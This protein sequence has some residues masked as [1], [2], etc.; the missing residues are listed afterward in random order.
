MTKRQ[1]R[2]R[3]DST[4]NLHR[5]VA[6][7]NVEIAPPAH[8]PLEEAD[9]PYWHSIIEEYAKADWTRH[10][11]DLAAFLARMMAN[12]EAQQRQLFAEGPVI[13]QSDGS[14][15]S[16][17]RNRVVATLNSQVLAFRRSL[18]LTARLKLGGTRDVARLR[19]ANRATERA[20]EDD[21]DLLA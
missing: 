15:G 12:L 1:R 6:G 20:A 16:N 14:L 2:T 7:A 5:I 9:W 10:T 11:L 21:D 4:A 18:G 17:P 19:V 8:I 13:T 3:T